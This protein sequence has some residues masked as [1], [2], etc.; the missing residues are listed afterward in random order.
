MKFIIHASKSEDIVEISS[1][2]V[3]IATEQDAL[4]IMANAGYQY[5]SRK[6]IVYKQNLGKSFFDLS[7]GLAG[8]I[9]QK[10]SNYRVRLA[11]VGDFTR[12]ESKRLQ[13]FIQESNKGKQVIFVNDLSEAREAL[14][15]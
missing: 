6:I 8:G 12:F 7:S 14:D 15:E 5:N 10:F 13:E 2:Q 4:D 9:L 3:V 11:V 1:D